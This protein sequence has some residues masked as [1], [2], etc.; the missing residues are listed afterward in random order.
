MTLAAFLSEQFGETFH[1]GLRKGIDTR[2]SVLA[3]NIVHLVPG[4]VWQAFC[5]YMI[6]GLQDRLGPLRP[7]DVGRLLGKWHSDPFLERLYGEHRDRWERLKRD[8][9]L[10]H[11]F[12]AAMNCMPQNDI[13]ALTEWFNYCYSVQPSEATAG[14]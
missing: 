8:M 3:Y 4:E 2:Y 7:E 11:T 6:A 5:A 9:R 1:T 13:P 12:D 14:R 10:I